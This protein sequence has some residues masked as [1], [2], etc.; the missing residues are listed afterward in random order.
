MLTPNL[1]MGKTSLSVYL[2]YNAYVTIKARD[3]VEIM[4][5]RQAEK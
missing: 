4:F 3:L 2:K 1:G 5:G